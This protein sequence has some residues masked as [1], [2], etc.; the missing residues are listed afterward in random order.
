MKSMV[1]TAR[2]PTHA[3]PGVDEPP[4]DEDPRV[5]AELE[6]TRH[7]DEETWW[8]QWHLAAAAGLCWL[9][10]LLG[11]G[12]DH[13]TSAPRTIV[14]ASFIAAY[15]A[16]GAYSAR[17]A[18][19]ELAQRRLNVDLLMIVAA[20]GA[21]IVDAWTEG[22]I[23]LGLFSLSNALQFAALGR[24]RRA[25]RALMELSPATA[26]LVR[27]DL[28]GG[29]AVV[30]VEQL[31]V[32]DFVLVRPGERVPIDG[33]VTEGSTGCDQAAITGE[34]I[35]VTKHAGDH[36][37][38][39]SI[40]VSGAVHL[41]VAAPHSESTLAKIIAFVEQAREQKSRTQRFT[42][43]FEGRYAGG[44]IV[45]SALVAV[46][47][48]LFFGA[49]L[50]DAFY[51]AMTLLVVAS[52]CAL[53]I[54]TPA[55]NLSG[56]ANAARHGV[57]F[58]GSGNLEDAGLIQTI[59]F[60]KTGTLTIG[61][62]RL[63]DL[64]PLAPGWDE[65]RLLQLAASA[66]RLSEHHLSYAMVNA[67]IER[68]LA[69][70][71]PSSFNALAGKGVRAFVLGQ[72]V[73]IGN[74][75]WFHE[76]GIPLDGAEAVAARFRDEGK[77]AVYVASNRQVVGV[78]AVADV[79]RP[80]AAAV[81]GQLRE[82]GVKR[83]VMMTGDNAAVARAIGRR[84]GIEEISAD[85]LPEQKLAMIEAFA[86][87]GSVAMIGDGVNDAPALAAATL[88]I[89]M[90]EGSDVALETADVVLMADDL[91]KLPYA[92]ALSRRT[93]RI[94]I[95][96]LSFALAVIATLAALALTVGIPLPLGVVGHEGS[97]VL[98]VLNGLR[99]L[100]EPIRREW[101]N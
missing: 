50:G 98:V 38:A 2:T 62:P 3:W 71:S 88:G 39:G 10:L 25:I 67:A 46:I 27:P 12:L 33:V 22:A 42:D 9:F 100:G 51:R 57:L 8:E 18:V 84:V 26:T 29:E 69:F 14:L 41:R 89:A 59:A 97:T 55:A 24:T 75:A 56:L 72:D 11:A 92:I 61:Q 96:N 99:L 1:L 21:A 32:G 86:A 54:S 93:R 91:T 35:P 28:P 47:P 76:L 5:R 82:L 63:T 19:E 34:S 79:V 53:V 80:E 16:G 30:P 68:G 90:G 7:G 13:F 60:D 78:V 65:A 48:W 31:A 45:A 20:F 43:K 58:R 44:V 73:A 87:D 95:Q 83:I 70:E 23:L 66:E 94:I 6:A 37:F 40:S 77:S 81:V 85:L 74:D 15:L 49:D 64:A 52:P 4:L 36:V 17:T 101:Q